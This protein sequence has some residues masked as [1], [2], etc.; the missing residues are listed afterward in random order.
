M[1]VAITQSRQGP[2]E[3]PGALDRL[4][5]YRLVCELGRGA[6][7]VVYRARDPVIEREVAIKTIR[8]DL[9]RD[10]VALFEAR[11]FTEIRAAGRLSHPNIVTVHDAGRE[12]ACCT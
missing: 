12:G 1:S 9:P 5:R 11:F 6:M 2:S 8:V 7:G 3:A 10:E 4:G